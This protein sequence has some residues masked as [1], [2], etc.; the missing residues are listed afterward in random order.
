MYGRYQHFFGL[1]WGWGIYRQMMRIMWHLLLLLT[2]WRIYFSWMLDLRLL[3][4]DTNIA[5]FWISLVRAKSVK[6]IDKYAENIMWRYLQVD[7]LF[8]SPHEIPYFILLSET[9]Q[10]KQFSDLN[11]STT[12]KR[13]FLTVRSVFQLWTQWLRL[14][15]ILSVL[16]VPW[17]EP[18]DKQL[19]GTSWVQIRRL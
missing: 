1:S 7:L 4:S 16:E 9:V 19:K 13:P 3:W 12:L 17:V 14:L 6:V 15:W 18:V 5:F 10:V 11:T 8:T 2:V